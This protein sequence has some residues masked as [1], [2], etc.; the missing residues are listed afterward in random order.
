MKFTAFA[1]LLGC[2]VLCLQSNHFHLQLPA[3]NGFTRMETALERFR[4]V[5]PSIPRAPKKGLAYVHSNRTRVIPA[6]SKE[7]TLALIKDSAA[8]YRVP[9]AFVTSIVA[10]ES[11]FD[12]RAISPKGAIGL[13]QLMPET[14][15]QYGADPAV[16]AQNIAAGTQYLRWLMQRYRKHHM[17]MQK[18]IAAYNSGPG[19][20]DRYRGIPPYH[21][22]RCYVTRVLS[23]MKQYSPSGRHPVDSRS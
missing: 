3:L 13:M 14:A 15:Q 19:V 10:A 16:P 11:N 20:V 1:L 9:A 21:E 7:E 17:A 2:S 23:Y 22:T 8:K 5:V 18:T 6:L 12:C 4:F